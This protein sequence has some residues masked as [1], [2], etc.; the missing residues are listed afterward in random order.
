MI[1]N[2]AGILFTSIDQIFIK[3]FIG[4]REFA[5]YSFAGTIVASVNLA[6]GPVKVSLYNWLCLEKDSKKLSML[7]GAVIILGLYAGVL[8]F[9]MNWAVPIWIPKYTQSLPISSV[10]FAAQVFLLIVGA[11]Y[12]NLYKATGRQKT[13]LARIIVDLLGNPT[14]VLTKTDR[15]V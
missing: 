8:A 7:R 5:Y 13:Y 1:G 14:K 11:V 3:N 10:L 4:L 2:Y 15:G 6:F 12:V 9:A